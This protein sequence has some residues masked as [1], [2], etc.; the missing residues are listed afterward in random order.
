MIFMTEPYILE[1]V[2]RKLTFLN[3]EAL[4]LS[5][6]C[7]LIGET[8]AIFALSGKTL[9]EILLFK[10]SNNGWEST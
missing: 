6:D 9:L 10:A 1:K 3:F 2:F 4:F 5:S 8:H 7:L